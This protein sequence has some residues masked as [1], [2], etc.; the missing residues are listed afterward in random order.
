MDYRLELLDSKTFERLVNSICQ[1]L[2]GIGV[3]SFSEGKDGGRDGKFEGEAKNFPSTTSSNWKGKFIIQ[4]KH[5]TNPI[6]SCGDSDFSNHIISKE[7]PK[8]KKLKENGEVE[9]YLLFTNRKYPAITGEKLTQKLVYE[10]GIQ[11]VTIIGKETLNDHYINPN[12]KLIRL[13][14]LDLFHIPFDFSDEEIKDLILGFKE[15]LSNFP[16]EF[17]QNP[18]TL[19]YDFD[20]VQIKKKNKRNNLGREYFEDNI[21]G[22]SSMD[23]DKIQRFLE[24]PINEEYKEVYF[25]IAAEINEMISLKRSNFGSFEEILVFL[26]KK[27]CDGESTLRGTKRHVSTLLHYMY[28][29]CLIGKR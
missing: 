17:G 2:L 15:Q 27:I 26:Y 22:R 10:T 24:N 23:F 16:E 9:C 8:L 13:Y 14:N 29:E 25:D 18:N 28:V 12:K 19:K 20:L 1:E 4:A 11:N 6:A 7:I 3:V 5:T 21:Q